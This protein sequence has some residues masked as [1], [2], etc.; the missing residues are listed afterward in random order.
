M[1]P[2]FLLPGLCCPGPPPAGL[3][4]SLAPS[5]DLLAALTWTWLT[6]DP[7]VQLLRHFW[8]SGNSRGGHILGSFHAPSKSGALLLLALCGSPGCLNWPPK[9]QLSAQD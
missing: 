9:L 1:V 8:T 6:V 7:L 5:Q 2:V 4:Y 3:L